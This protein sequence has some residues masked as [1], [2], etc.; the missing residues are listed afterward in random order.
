MCSL[1]FRPH[2]PFIVVIAQWQKSASPPRLSLLCE[3]VKDGPEIFTLN[4][5]TTAD[6]R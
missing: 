5:S 4:K 6:G 3:E 2:L 1:L